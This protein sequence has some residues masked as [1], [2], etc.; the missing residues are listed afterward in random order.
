VGSETHVDGLE[1]MLRS[2]N[3]DSQITPD[4]EIR[5]LL[6]Q[7]VLGGDL[8]KE[9]FSKVVEAECAY[10]RRIVQN[11][12][13][14]PVA[15]R[16]MRL[17]LLSPIDSDQRGASYCDL[18]IEEARKKEEAMPDTNHKEAAAWQTYKAMNF[19]TATS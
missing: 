5:Q 14:K 17:S 7:R 4:S 16:L 8:S 10:A 13:G 18:R 2:L 3:P 19:S 6:D 15:E 9:L 11:A 1:I 12:G